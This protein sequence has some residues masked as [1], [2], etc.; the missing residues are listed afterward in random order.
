LNRIKIKKDLSEFGGNY[1]GG[2]GGEEESPLRSVKDK[3]RAGRVEYSCIEIRD[4]NKFP[5]WQE[6][7]WRNSPTWDSERGEKQASNNSKKRA[8]WGGDL[9]SSMIDTRRRGG[10]GQL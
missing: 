7:N 10:H 6:K 9:L 2:G 4:V 1:F 8:G 3:R 5:W